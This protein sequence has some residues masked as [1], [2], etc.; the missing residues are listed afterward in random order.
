MS[1]RPSLSNRYDPFVVGPF[2]EGKALGF[3]SPRF[4]PNPPPTVAAEAQ[5]PNQ[6]TK[7]PPLPLPKPQNKKGNHTKDVF[8]HP[9]D[10]PLEI[11]KRPKHRAKDELAGK[12][13]EAWLLWRDDFS[14]G[15]T[16][17][18]HLQP[19]STKPSTAKELAAVSK[20]YELR[21]C[22]Q[23]ASY[24]TTSMNSTAGSGKS[25]ARRLV[26]K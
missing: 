19:D 5:P 10:L 12:V 3:F 11:I 26:G 22:S 15:M 20:L 7:T 9:F 24:M 18:T 4:R 13:K 2:R 1:A 6:K 23:L 21:G 25:G 14:N 8:K 16:P 17:I